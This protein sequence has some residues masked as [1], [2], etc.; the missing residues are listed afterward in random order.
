MGSDNVIQSAYPFHPDEPDGNATTNPMTESCPG[1]RRVLVAICNHGIKNQQYLQRLLDEYRSMV[2]HDV[3]IVV[4]SNIPRNY[5]VDV[6][7]QVGLPM[8]DPWSLPFG[9][10]ELFAKRATEY[11]L[12]IYTEDDTLITERNIDA[13]VEETRIL[14]EEY[15]AGFMHFEVSPDGRKSYTGMHSQ[16]HWDP[17]SV[18]RIGDSFFA[19]HTNEHSACFILTKK[20]LRKAIDSGGFMLPPRRGRYDMLV[21]ASTEPYME[22]GMKKMICIS[23]FDDFCIHHLPNIY[24]GKCGLDADFG[25]LEIECLGSISHDGS[26]S[27]RGP[28][29]EHY[30]LRDGDSWNKKYYES[31][32]DDILKL[33]P[34]RARR[35]LS[36]GCGCGTTEEILIRSGIEVVGIPLDAIIGATA[37]AK[38]IEILSPDFELAAKQL[39]R[40]QFDCILMMDILQQ[41]RDP[42]AIIKQYSVFLNDGGAVLVSV[43]NWNYLGILRQRLTPQGRSCLEC[44]ATAHSAGVQRTT[45]ARVTGWLRQSGLSRV[46]HATVPAPRLED[47]HKRTFGLLDEFLCRNLLILARR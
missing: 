46:T 19:Y 29:F 5:D 31:R 41:L 42:V 36:V 44:R 39:D 24:L 32:R 2:R 45:M 28:L 6:E 40:Q 14:P 10:K 22:C 9:Y 33:V 16:F 25:K 12:F 38:G 43:P 20:Q 17:N 34:L 47:F 7:V 30:P 3:T 27:P 1:P 13:F 35:I 15:I 23:R 11:D 4:L 18:M 8:A 21:T 26:D 37:A